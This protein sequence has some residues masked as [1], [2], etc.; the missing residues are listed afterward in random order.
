MDGLSISDVLEPGVWSHDIRSGDIAF[1]TA[2]HLREVLR[3]TTG[4]NRRKHNARIE[5]LHQIFLR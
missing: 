3:N 1:A 4:G 5:S 2:A